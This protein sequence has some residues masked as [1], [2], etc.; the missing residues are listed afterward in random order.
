MTSPRG[1]EREKLQDLQDWSSS[2]LKSI[3]VTHNIYAEVIITRRTS[4]WLYSL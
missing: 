1:R 4:S 2:S 3:W